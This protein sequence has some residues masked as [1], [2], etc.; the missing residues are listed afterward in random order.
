MKLY[1]PEEP[2]FLIR[3]NIK[4]QGQKTEHINLCETSQKECYNFVKNLIEKQ[5]LSIFQTG[6]LTNIEFREAKG[7]ENLNSISLSF[8]GIDPVK[9]KTLILSTL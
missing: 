3:I 2:P 8:K 1:I 9:V 7:S 4:K 6:K 5:N